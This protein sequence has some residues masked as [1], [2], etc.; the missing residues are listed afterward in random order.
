[1]NNKVLLSNQNPENS[2]NLSSWPERQMMMIKLARADR[3]A[4]NDT[5]NQAAARRR[6]LLK[7]GDAGPA[8][9][10]VE[11]VHGLALQR[12]K[13]VLQEVKVAH[14]H[15][16]LYVQTGI[17]IFSSKEFPENRGKVLKNW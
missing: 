5:A 10:P 1:M 9:T 16:E 8:D 14:V 13:L 2:N 4:A 17:N 7:V 11:V 3:S 6:A 12:L 15:A